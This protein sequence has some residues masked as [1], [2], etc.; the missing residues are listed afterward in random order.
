MI[1]FAYQKLNAL[2]GEIL[3]PQQLI[4]S[5]NLPYDS[6]STSDDITSLYFNP[7]GIGIHPLQIG[8]FYGHNEKELLKD[9]VVFMNLFGL[10]FSTQMRFAD[11][12]YY[13]Y[14]YTAGTGLGSDSIFSIGTSYS[15]FNSNVALLDNYGQWDIG[16]IIRPFSFL[17][18]GTVFRSLNSKRDE[19]NFLKSRY[20]LGIGIRPIPNYDKLTISVDST[21]HKGQPLKT[22]LPRYA[23]EISSSAG[24]ALYGG[25]DN[26][27]NFFLG[28]KFAQD[29]SQ[30]SFQG[31]YRKEEGN[32]YSGGILIGKERFETKYEAIR[33]YL[34]ISLETPFREEKKS[35]FLFLGENITF[36][37]ILKAIKTAINDPQINGILITG[38][39]F[40][41]GWGQAE[42]LRNAISNFKKKSGKAVIA[43]LESAGNKEY[44]IASAADSIVMPPVSTLD[45]VG[46]KAELI[47]IKDLFNKVGL[48]AD[49]VHIGDYK[50]APEL[51]ENSSPSKYNEEQT[52][53]LLNKLNNEIKTSILSD[54]KKINKDALENI[55]N[56]GILPSYKAKELGLIDDV[57]YFSNLTEKLTGS[58]Y[59]KYKWKIPIKN[60]INVNFYNDK[61]GPQDI[62][63]ILVI[64]GDIIQGKSR[65]EGIL[66]SASAGSDTISEILDNLR[67][68]YAVKAVVIRINS[69]GG[70]GA[71]S[72]IIWEK[73]NLLKEEK[74]VIISF[75][76][77]AASGGYYIAAG[78]SKIISNKT[79]ITG[80]IGVYGGKISLKGLYKMLGVNKYIYKTN[81]NAAIF[82]ETD[83][84]TKAEKELLYENL[85][86]FYELFLKRVQANRKNLTIEKIEQNARGRVFT[87]EEA[88]ERGMIDKT[89]GLMMAVEMAR[90]KAGLNE[91]N[92]KIAFYPHESAKILSLSDYNSHIIPA[93]IK[94]TMRLWQRTEEI[95]DEKIFFM[96][97]Y[98]I[99]I[100]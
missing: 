36:F 19:E 15:W 1:G 81:K 49:F 31:T 13:A 66:S 61:W 76:N 17:S 77:V 24:A 71:A 29:I 85:Y 79:S 74:P 21:L 44:Y 42:E 35:S 26:Y 62:L 2:T 52:I 8:Y 12:G 64:E 14:R 95:E 9:H 65:E 63:A 96:L 38:R 27:S 5:P 57:A 73:I 99:N 58:K 10:A 90:I 4:E 7:A 67:N 83:T 50:S 97:P 93:A 89:G 34:E 30:I 18:V 91:D 43:Y 60:Y 84:F 100:E 22:M 48:Q 56:T 59:G 39:I 23:V 98:N 68:S 25:W 37:E 82:S 75:S 45:I 11:E 78:G 46:L 41:G 53:N 94:E 28:L 33:G 3:Q 40:N 55:M 6:I 16:L 54:R 32:F 69:P 20:E 86:E 92:V 47:F 72:D 87:G 80:S 88:L 51:Y 70:S